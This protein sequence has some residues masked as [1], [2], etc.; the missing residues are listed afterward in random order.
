LKV[1]QREAKQRRDSIEAYRSA[2]R[3]DLAKVEEAEL[4]IIQE[5]LPEALSEAELSAI[6]DEVIEQT[7]ASSAAQM[8]AVVGG[9]MARVGAQ[10][11]GG[12]VS[13]IVREKLNS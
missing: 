2:G 11:E 7:G 3:E 5:Y 6:V 12:V 9:V 13:K 4:E 1:V 10:A 8:G